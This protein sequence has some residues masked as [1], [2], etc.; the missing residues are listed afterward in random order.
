VTTAIPDPRPAQVAIDIGGT[1]TDILVSDGATIVAKKVPSTPDSPATAVMA[2]LLTAEA[3]LEMVNFFVHGQTVGLN[4]FLERKGVRVLLLMTEGASDSY[5]IARHDRKELWALRYRKPARLVPRRDVHEVHERLHADGTIEIQLD[6]RSLDPVIDKIAADQISSV[7]VCLLHSYL[8]PV[9]EIAVG[10][11]L[12]E[13]FPNL[14][15]TLSHE[16]AREWR[17]YERASTAVL[18]AYIAPSVQTYLSTLVEQLERV[19]IKTPPMIMQSSGGVTTV[20]AVRE[21]P[22]K[23]LMSG[24]VGGTVGGEVLARIIG[25]PNLLCVDMGGTSFDLS[26]IVQ[27]R[28][29]VTTEVEL[30]GLPALVP[31]IDIRTIGAGGGSIAWIEAG[32]LRVGPASAGANPGP[33]CYGRGGTEPTVT[34]ANLLLGRIS[35]DRFADATLQ[36]DVDASARAIAPLARCLDLDETRLAAGIISII[37]ARMADAMR[38]ITVGQGIDPR[39][40]SLV[41]YGGGGPAHAA[42]LMAELDMPEAIIP[43]NPGTFSAWGMLQSHRRYDLSAPF[44]ANVETVDRDSLES[45]FTE[46]QHE[47]ET[48]FAANS[49]GIPT[50]DR[51]ADVRYV[52]QEY[53][54]QVDAKGG[55]GELVAQFH[56]AHQAR[57]GHS[58][59]AAPVEIVNLRVALSSKGIST[60][61]EQADDLTAEPVNTRLRMVFFVEDWVSTQIIARA[62]LPVGHEV[63]GPA[64]IEEQTSTTIVPP[65]FR[66]VVDQTRNLI[67]TRSDV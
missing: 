64:V 55:P 17:E 54:L 58:R 66:A 15:V 61:S 49:L 19:D 47:G 40:F 29:R 10:H 56:R 59:P 44:Y 6:R 23:T 13:R 11:A 31:M 60:L 46:L 3:G 26:L 1:F 21:R 39:E 38:A 24:P 36:L 8:N 42:S 34:D 28:P 52:G 41:V 12:Q 37:N 7:A 16:V 45:I 9:H 5:T 27:G 43:A 14:A 57:F 25:R 32:G 62:T 63:S 53:T 18:N 48:F 4:A 35:A 50:V 33:A 65:G 22:V 51:A 20:S 30:Q 67:L 2:A